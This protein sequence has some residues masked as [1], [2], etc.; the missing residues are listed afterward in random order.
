MKFSQEDTEQEVETIIHS[1][2]DKPPVQDLRNQALSVCRNIECVFSWSWSWEVWLS[3]S[4]HVSES[5]TIVTWTFLK[6][7]SGVFVISDALM[8]ESGSHYIF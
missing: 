6:L 5:F 2:A 1:P 3:P 4:G 7:V 8:T